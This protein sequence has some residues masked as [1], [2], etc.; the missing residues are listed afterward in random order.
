[1]T[2][3]FWHIHN[4]FGPIV[5]QIAG[6]GVVMMKMVNFRNF[7]FTIV[8]DQWGLAQQQSKHTRPIIKKNRV[9]KQGA[10][11]HVILDTQTDKY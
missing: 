9:T 6:L 3:K 2:F 10:K 1:M 7:F 5:Y 11:T 8:P 4:D